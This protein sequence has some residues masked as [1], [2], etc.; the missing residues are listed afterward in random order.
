MDKKALLELTTDI[1]SAHASVNEMG[2]EELLEELQSVVPEVTESWRIRG[3]EGAG[4][5]G[6]LKPAVPVNKG[7]RRRTSR[8]PCVRKG[9]RR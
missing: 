3:E 5:S 9:S 1:V 6:E 4:V 7:V 8:L 2:K